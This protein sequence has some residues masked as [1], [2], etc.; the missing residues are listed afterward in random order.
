VN[1]AAAGAERAYYCGMHVY[2]FLF[3]GIIF[4]GG[5][6]ATIWITAA[7]IALVGVIAWWKS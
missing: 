4:E 2:D 3:S 6:S 1:R 5:D 7:I